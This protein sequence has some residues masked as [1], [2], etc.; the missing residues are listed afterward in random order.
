MQKQKKEVKNNKMY[1]ELG[2][3]KTRSKLFNYY[4]K[5]SEKDYGIR[6]HLHLGYTAE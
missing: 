5:V 3:D 1:E 4:N 2:F 6:L